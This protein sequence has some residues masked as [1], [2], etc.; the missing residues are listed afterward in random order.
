[1]LKQILTFVRLSKLLAETPWKNIW[2]AA[3]SGF[4]NNYRLMWRRF[5]QPTRRT[6]GCWWWRIC[7]TVIELVLTFYCLWPCIDFKSTC[8]A[9]F[10][11]SVLCDSWP[12]L[13]K[14]SC[15][16]TIYELQDF[17]KLFSAT[18]WKGPQ[19]IRGL[20]KVLTPSLSKDQNDVT[21]QHFFSLFLKKWSHRLMVLGIC[22]H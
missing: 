17:P 13:F 19:G 11:D 14:H 20:L 15:H 1:M 16:P 3:T 22:S 5:I 7:T 4:W 9:Q 18:L 8:G 6:A 10:V 21:G 2:L 12:A